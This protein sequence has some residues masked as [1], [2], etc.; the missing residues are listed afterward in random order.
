[1]VPG[2]RGS[3]VEDINSFLRPVVDELSELYYT[4]FTCFDADSRTTF[5]CYVKLVY[6]VT[7]NEAAMK[8]VCSSSLSPTLYSYLLLL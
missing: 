6:F 5:R 4:G 8:V 7:D 2:E 1:M 3:S